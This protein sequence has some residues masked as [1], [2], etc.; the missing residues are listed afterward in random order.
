MGET[1]YNTSHH[2]GGTPER[3]LLPGCATAATLTTPNILSFTAPGLREP[4]QTSITRAC[5]NMASRRLAKVIFTATS[6][7]SCDE[8]RRAAG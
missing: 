5:M 6:A 1:K 4:T 7:G 3:G 8:H 2:A